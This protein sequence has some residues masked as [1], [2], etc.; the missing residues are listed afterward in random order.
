VEVKRA[1][2]PVG[3]AEIDETIDIMRKQRAEFESVSRAAATGDRVTIDFKGTQ[4]GVAFEGGTAQGY[5]FVLGEGR[6]LPEFEAAVAGMAPGQTK[7]FP[8]TFPDDYG[9]RDL[10]GKTV[11]FEVSVAKVEEPRLPAIDADF[12]KS[13]GIE[14]GDVAKM[15]AEIKSNL[16]REV[17]SR[18]K[19]RT[20]DS[21]MEAL[22]GL[23]QFELPK[24]LVA[25]D[26]QRLIEMARADM[27]S[28]GMDVKDAPIPPELFTAQAE[29]R[30]RLGLVV[31]EVV[32]KE[33]LA[34]RPD[35]VRRLVEEMAQSYERPQD[36]INWYLSDRKR[37]A[38]LESVALENNV[39]D[40]VLG[41]AKVV[42]TAV[43]F[44]E[45]MGRGAPRK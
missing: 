19:S 5:P 45:L 40:W 9:S 1:V 2:C 10:A 17:S 22:A 30:V 33:G 41:K 4:D 32:A 35:Q 7:T 20:K 24:A 38:E 39:M 37:L 25:E 42:D 8:L 13:L 43:A 28:R 23:A 29:R 26:Q 21:V 44:D 11:Q 27:A 18:L 6:M 31:G 36:V 3:E 34:V 14:D 16:D 15:R 12:A